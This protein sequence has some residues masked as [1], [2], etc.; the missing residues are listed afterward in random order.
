[1]WNLHLCL[2]P[3]ALPWGPLGVAHSPLEFSVHRTT[4]GVPLGY[5]HA[6][7]NRRLKP[8]TG[9]EPLELPLRVSWL[10]VTHLEQQGQ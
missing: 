3:P 2:L 8:C 10:A 5:P 9:H 4:S 1:M 7:K 6:G